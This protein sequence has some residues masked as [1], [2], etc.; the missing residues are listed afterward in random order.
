MRNILPPAFILTGMH[1]S[2][3]SLLGR[4]LAASRV[5]MGESLLPANAGNRRGYFE[6][7]EILEFHRRLLG[8]EFNGE[9]QW[10]PGPPRFVEDDRVDAAGLI[11]KR[12]GAG[13]P[14]GW[15]EPRTCLFLDFWGELAPEAKFLFVFRAPEAV[16][17]SLARRHKVP[18]ENRGTYDRFL[19]AWIVYNREILNFYRKQRHRCVLFSLDFCVGNPV[20]FVDFLSQRC[21]YDFHLASFLESYDGGLLK[22]DPEIQSRASLHLRIRAAWMYRRLLALGQS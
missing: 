1:R 15:K 17:D 11:A 5:H 9:Q 8:R 3:T 6:D 10:A 18:L 22:R 7:I 13:R 19:G 14:W 12:R 20:R 4:F 2:G 16:V 21:R